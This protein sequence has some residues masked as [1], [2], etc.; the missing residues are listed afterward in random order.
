MRS[1]FV[2]RLLLVESKSLEKLFSTI[3]NNIYYLEN[4]SSEMFVSP[5]LNVVDK[6]SPM[7]MFEV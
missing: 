4:I 5:F 3:E 7:I 1:K 2:T 6:K